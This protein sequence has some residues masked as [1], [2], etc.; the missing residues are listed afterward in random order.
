MCPDACAFLV[1]GLRVELGHLLRL[2][3]LLLLAKHVESAPPR[4][5]A[6]LARLASHRRM[7][8]AVEVLSRGALA[9]RC[10]HGMGDHQRTL[11]RIRTSTDARQSGCRDPRLIYGFTGDSYLIP[12][13]VKLHRPVKRA[14]I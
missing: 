4:Y 6:A 12:K 13:D 14:K 1:A 2:H 7:P 8:A 10:C 11:Q 3:T 5:Q 9:A